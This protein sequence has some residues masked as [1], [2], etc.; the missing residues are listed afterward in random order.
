MT[1]RKRMDDIKTGAG[2]LLRD[3]LGGDL[4][5]ARVVSGLKVAR[6]RLRLWCGTWEPASRYGPALVA[7]ES[8]IP[9]QRK[10]RGAE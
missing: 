4:L 8:E 10:L 5:T 1:G 9:K 6:A 3:E 2:S 7:G